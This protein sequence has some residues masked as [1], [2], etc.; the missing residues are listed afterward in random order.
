MSIIDLSAS[1]VG[2][3]LHASMMD[4]SVG[5]SGI[6]DDPEINDLL[7][8]ARFSMDPG[9]SAQT[10]KRRE[11]KTQEDV[12]DLLALLSHKHTSSIGSP[13]PID[14]FSNTI[15]TLYSFTV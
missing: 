15:V 6:M 3:A 1:A 12:D 11:I 9:N 10:L 13:F 7:E 8:I 2:H 14:S 4:T 5:E